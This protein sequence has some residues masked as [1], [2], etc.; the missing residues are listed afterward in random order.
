MK[1]KFKKIPDYFRTS[2]DEL[3][4]VAWPTRKETTKNTL[5]VIGF[6]AAV[7]IF[8]GVIDYLLNL[9]LQQII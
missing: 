8:L 3:K 6:S 7:G 4:K 5:V 2:R 1:I 9:G